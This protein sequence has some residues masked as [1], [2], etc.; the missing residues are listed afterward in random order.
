MKLV[1]YLDHIAEV[2]VGFN[3]TSYSDE[4]GQ[5]ISFIIDILE[6]QA[7]A[8]VFVNFAT[9]DVTASGN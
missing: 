1:Y 3:P 9:S 4:E 8:D 2:T 6:G 5:A 7:Q